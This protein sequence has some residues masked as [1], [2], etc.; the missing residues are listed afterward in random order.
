[1]K[2]R[3][4]LA[5]LVPAMVMSMVACGQK[6]TIDP[7]KVEQAEETEPMEADEEAGAEVSETS[8]AEASSAN[9][10]VQMLTEEEYEAKKAEGV[11]LAESGETEYAAHILVTF[12]QDVTSFALW[13]LSSDFQNEGESLVIEGLT[14]LAELDEI[15]ANEPV[16]VTISLGEILPTAGFTYV[17]ED[18]IMRRCYLGESGMDGSAFYE[19]YSASPKDN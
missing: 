11:Q 13:R 9:V 12:S 18:G 2:K 14:A 4:V 8:G 10:T 3:I 7:V 1:M 16:I 19:E 5:V 6:S 17:D 15:K